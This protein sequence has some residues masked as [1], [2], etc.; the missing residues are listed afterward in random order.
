MRSENDVG[1]SETPRIGWGRILVGTF[2]IMSSSYALFNPAHN[3]FEIDPS[4]ENV[5]KF[6][7]VF[8]YTSI[9]A[10]AMLVALGVRARFTR[11]ILR[12]LL[13]GGKSENRS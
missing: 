11:L 8:T 6:T 10:G 3:R 9:L 7:T 1:R 4:D 5:K 2:L 12:G 13:K